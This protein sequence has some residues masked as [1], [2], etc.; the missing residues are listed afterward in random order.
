MSVEEPHPHW[1]IFRAINPAALPGYNGNLSDWWKVRDAQPEIFALLFQLFSNSPN[2]ISSAVSTWKM[3][4]KTALWG[5]DAL[6]TGQQLQPNQGKGQNKTK[7]N[8]ISIGNLDNF[9]LLELLRI[10]GFYEAGQTRLVQGVKDRKSYVIV[11]REL[12]YNEHRDIFNTFS[13]Q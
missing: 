3:L 10:S 2:D 7:A 11:P 12:T 5:I 9:W 6:S 4:D 13:D 8:G 1:D